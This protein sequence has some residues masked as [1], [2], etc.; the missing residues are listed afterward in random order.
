EAVVAARSGDTARRATAS[1]RRSVGAA[2]GRDEDRARRGTVPSARPVN[3]RGSRLR[4]EVE[5]AASGAGAAD[6]S[7]EPLEAGAVDT[8]CHL[9]LIEADPSEIVEEARA[10]GVS[11][12]VCVGIDPESSRR[13]LEL[14]ESFRGVFATAG[15]HPHTASSFDRAAGAAVEELV[16]DPMVVAV[17]ETGLDYYRTLSPVEDQRPAF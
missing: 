3:E 16:A 1:R 13:S 2:R 6:N 15:V 12:L 14:A 7:R 9:F 17:G 8:H 4:A 5:T 11:T 10:A